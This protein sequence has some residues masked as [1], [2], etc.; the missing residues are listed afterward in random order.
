MAHMTAEPDKGNSKRSGPAHF[1]YIDAV[2]G[3]AFLGVMTVHAAMSVGQFPARNLF[4]QAGYGV[5]LFFLASAITLSFSMSARR[6]IDRYPTLYFYLRRLFRIAPLFWAAMAFYWIFPRVMPSFWLSEWAPS[7]VHPLYFVLTALFLHGWHPYAFNSIVPGGWSIA[8]EMNFYLLFPLLYR[9]LAKSLRRSAVAVVVSILCV[10][11]LD[12]YLPW[13]HQYVYSSIAATPWDFYTNF[14]LPSQLP[15]FL[16]GF[17]ACHLIREDA[18]TRLVQ[19]R[20]WAAW[21]VFFCCMAILAAGV[22]RETRF[23]RGSLI[24]VMALAAFV[25]VLARGSLKWIVNP[26]I[27]YLGKISY[28]CYLVHFAAMGLTLKLLGIHLTAN[29]TLVDTGHTL[30]NCRLFLEIVAITL[31]LTALIATATLHLIENPGIA[32]GKK[33][34]SRI[35]AFHDKTGLRRPIA[36]DRPAPAHQ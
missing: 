16:I 35:T 24:V 9:L 25:L 6:S 12:R 1:A 27:C 5:Q 33:L 10:G 18:I 21:P 3:I 30:G 15:V 29:S 7:G 11:L 20:S 22:G 8:V 32:L 19:V 23:M 13:L 26:A 28:S 14:W 17:L 36:P 4:T 2:R 31:T 34:L